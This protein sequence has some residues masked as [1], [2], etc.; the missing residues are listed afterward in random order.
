MV[1]GANLL[2]TILGHD[3]FKQE[4]QVLLTDRGS[5]FVYADALE[6]SINDNI[7]RKCSIVTL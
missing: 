5:E 1:N 4:V 3:L 2:V 6:K 7:Q